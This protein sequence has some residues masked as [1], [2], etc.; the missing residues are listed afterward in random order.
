MP[1]DLP[2]IAFII[3]NWNNPADT[4]A[5]VQ[6]LQTSEIA[7]VSR[8]NILVVDNGS[9]DDSLVQIEAA[10]S[11]VQII[12]NRQNLGYAGG[13]NAAMRVA[14]AQGVDYVCILNND[15][16][17][18]PHF[19]EPLLNVM[20]FDAQIGVATPVITLASEPD[21]VWAAGA[22]IDLQT[23]QVQRLHAGDNAKELSKHPAYNVQIAPGAAFLV[24]CSTLEQV[25]LLDEA[26][27][28]YYEEI[29]WSL[30]VRQAGFRIV[31]VPQSV[32]L[33]KVSATLGQTS[34]V[35]DYYMARNRYYFVAR[36][37]H[38]ST[39]L[40]LFMHTFF[41]QIATILAYSVKK[42]SQARL[43]RRDVR[44][45]ALRDGLL[46]RWGEMGADVTARCFSGTG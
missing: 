26:Y 6:A 36:N 34:P 25:G 15:V 13:N 23:G 43:L 20:E 38:G 24:R 7:N 10:C 41:E 32:V 19:L 45:L 42:R 14:L 8:C 16:I 27:F 33:H 12:E 28:L 35:T 40:R 4:I 1:K 37:W 17:V 44:L 31:T 18:M 39:R 9:T 21:E 29:D 30:R 5:C 46:G 22:D 3:L 2:S 11:D